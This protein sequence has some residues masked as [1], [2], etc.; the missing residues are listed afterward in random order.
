[1][2]DGQ[3]NSAS[4]QGVAEPDLDE[5]IQDAFG[6]NIRGVQTLWALLAHPSRVF[7]AAQSID[8]AGRFTPSIRLAFSIVALTILSRP[9]GRGR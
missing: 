2:A 8:W 9:R 7:T 1:M 6:L 3:H 5:L 4:R